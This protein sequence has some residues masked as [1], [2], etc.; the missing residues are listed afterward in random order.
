MRRFDEMNRDLVRSLDGSDM[1][2]SDVRCRQRTPPP[3][4]NHI[5]ATKRCSLA[6]PFAGKV[7]AHPQPVGAV[8]QNKIGDGV[9]CSDCFRHACDLQ[10]ALVQADALRDRHTASKQMF[11]HHW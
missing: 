5:S 3:D 7:M 9:A 6:S 8:I 11:G 1:Q 4:D 2:S 10:H